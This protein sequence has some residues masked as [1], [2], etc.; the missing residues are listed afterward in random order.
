MQYLRVR[1]GLQMLVAVAAEH[2]R[3]RRC[4]VVAAAGGCL[5]EPLVPEMLGTGWMWSLWDLVGPLTGGT[6]A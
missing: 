1:P 5:L 3:V 4:W 2:V 6:L